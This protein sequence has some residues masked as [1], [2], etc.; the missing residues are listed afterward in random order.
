MRRH[1]LILNFVAVTVIAFIC[2]SAYGQNE[3]GSSNKWNI[4]FTPYFW[5]AELKGDA[6]LRGRT[7]PVE[8]SFSDLLDNL[9]I[10]FMGRAEAWKGR[11]G[12]FFDGLY[13]DL[14][15]EFST[16]QGL[17]SADIDVKMTML[18]FGLGYR[19]WE[20]QVGK[21]GSQKLSF[22]LLG[23][24]LYMNLYGEG[25]IVPGGPLGVLPG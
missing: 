2:F 4:E 21:E 19:L 7:G 24:G 10:A 16:P 23:G 25:D 13:M 12:L 6:T 8:V 14:G 5:A 22:V 18:E 1:Y 15:A 20:T 17:V 9:D 11:W 3:V